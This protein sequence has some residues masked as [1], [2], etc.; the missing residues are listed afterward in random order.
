MKVDYFELFPFNIKI[1]EDSIYGLMR[2]HVFTCGYNKKTIYMD[3]YEESSHD[4]I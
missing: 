2:N 3:I 1:T 4:M